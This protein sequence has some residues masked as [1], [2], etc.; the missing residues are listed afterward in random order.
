MLCPQHSQNVFY[1]NCG[2]EIEDM[3]FCDCCLEWYHTACTNYKGGQDEEG[4][5]KF[6]CPFCISWGQ[7]KAKI[8]KEIKSDKI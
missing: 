6:I 5:E 4:E 3:V 7:L 2:K 8:L 1:C